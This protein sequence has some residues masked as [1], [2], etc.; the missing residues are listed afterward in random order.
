MGYT[1]Y[2]KKEG[3][4]KQ[5]D[6]EKAL[7]D[8]RTIVKVISSGNCKLLNDRILAGGDGS[9]SPEYK[10]D[11]CFNG[12]ADLAHETFALPARAN[13]LEEFDFCK[14]NRKPYD[15]VVVAC[16]AILSSVSGIV[17]SSDGNKE[18]WLEGLELATDILGL[19]IQD[20]NLG[21]LT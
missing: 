18:D 6:Y 4:V 2:W 19:N 11:I 21:D 5:K 10:K 9:G 13:D 16:L 3:R 17:V 12:V 1:H 7:E 8:C 20:S 15:K 14:T